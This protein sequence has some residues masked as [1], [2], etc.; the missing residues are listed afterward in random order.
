M[1]NQEP[2][3]RNLAALLAISFSINCL[4]YLK[5][6]TLYIQG[7]KTGMLIDTLQDV[8]YKQERRSQIVWQLLNQTVAER[9]ECCSQKSQYEIFTQDTIQGRKEFY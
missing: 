5:N 3:L 8:I 9:D 1:N 6:D 4:L 2:R 7:K